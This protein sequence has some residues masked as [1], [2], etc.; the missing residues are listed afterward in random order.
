M[1]IVLK[2]N[3]LFRTSDRCEIQVEVCSFACREFPSM[4]NSMNLLSAEEWNGLNE[5]AMTR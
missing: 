5:T 1:N 2:Q 4:D 3:T